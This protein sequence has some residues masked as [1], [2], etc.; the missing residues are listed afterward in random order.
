MILRRTPQGGRRLPASRLPHLHAL[1]LI[2]AATTH[3]G[4]D[5]SS[6]PG[7]LWAQGLLTRF[8][9]A[10]RSTKGRETVEEG[11]V[12]GIFPHDECF[13]MSF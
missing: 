4:R 13:E 11:P 2:L 8:F 9:W 3:A 10:V 6:K 7:L 5:W 1:L 12:E